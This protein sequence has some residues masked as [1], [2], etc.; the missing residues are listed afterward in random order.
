M[1]A[2]HQLFL[3]AIA[4]KRRVSVR[5]KHPKEVREMVCTCAPLDFGP[6]RGSKDPEPR[7]QLWDLDAKRRPFNLA[8]RA[9][10]IL[11]LKL[12]EETFDPASIITWAFKAGAW[13]IPRDWAE[14]S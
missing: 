14:F 6:L 11:E 10:E 9:S 2:D 7:Y 1:P 3:D 12:L 13:A 5:F 4:A 8:L